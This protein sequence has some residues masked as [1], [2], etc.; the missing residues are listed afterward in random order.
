QVKSPG[1]KPGQGMNAEV[2][3]ATEGRRVGVGVD[4][5]ETTE[6]RGAGEGAMTAAAAAGTANGPSTCVRAPSPAPHAFGPPSERF[7][8]LVPRDFAREHLVLSAGRDGEVE[9]M[10]VSERTDP[11]AAHNV[12][13]R[14][15]AWIEC[16]V[17]D[18]EALARAI[19]AAYTAARARAE[20][21]AG[22]VHDAAAGNDDE[23]SIERLLA[24]AD[25]DLLATQGKG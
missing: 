24:Q 14:L 13:T 22:A 10:L 17:V 4:R 6:R 20:A 19:D 23:N 8:S 9:R 12:G 18:G 25:R 5:S 11:A 15:G 16:E 7:L 3:Q 1:R 21:S 2:S